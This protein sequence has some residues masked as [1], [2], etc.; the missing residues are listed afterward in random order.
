[1][2]PLN[3]KQKQAIG[4]A[5]TDVKAHWAKLLQT[6][7]ECIQA[8]LEDEGKASF[9]FRKL[10]SQTVLEVINDVY[11]KKPTNCESNHDN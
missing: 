8:M 5:R 1:M 6:T 11:P 9:L 3:D 4:Q 10:F 2:K 7:P